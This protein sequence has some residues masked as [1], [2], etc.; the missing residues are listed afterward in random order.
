LVGV[1]KVLI[2][3][4]A[5]NEQYANDSPYLFVKIFSRTWLIS[6]CVLMCGSHVFHGTSDDTWHTLQGLL[7]RCVQSLRINVH[8]SFPRI[9]MNLIYCSCY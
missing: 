5:G 4:K 2:Y 3:H 7:N 6:T 1:T 8:W 9:W